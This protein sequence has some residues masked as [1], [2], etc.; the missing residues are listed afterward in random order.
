MVL[1]KVCRDLL[2]ER[3]RHYE[4]FIAE[5][6]S[7]YKDLIAEKDS[8]CE[9]LVAE[10][11][12]QCSKLSAEYTERLVNER[13]AASQLLVEQKDRQL[14]DV[15][16]SNS[17]LISQSELRLKQALNNTETQF[18]TLNT[19]MKQQQL[20]FVGFSIA[21][22]FVIITLLVVASYEKSR[23]RLRYKAIIQEKCD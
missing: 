9:V 15:A 19:T 21:A 2:D 5:K 14:Q 12:T 13:S 10:K 22:V 1:K 4:V 11:D 6:D 8:H 23:I 16:R 20:I 18:Q 17:Y 7:H 3:D